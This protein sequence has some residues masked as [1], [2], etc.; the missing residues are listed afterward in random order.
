LIDKVYEAVRQIAIDDDWTALRF[1]QTHFIKSL[2][3][4]PGMVMGQESKART[5]SSAKE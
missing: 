4:Q 2:K 1:R 5:A 3:R